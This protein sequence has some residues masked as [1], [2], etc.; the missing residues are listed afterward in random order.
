MHEWSQ[1]TS[2]DAIV[3]VLDN[4]PHVGGGWGILEIT[5]R[6]GDL[7]SAVD[8]RTT[9]SQFTMEFFLHSCLPEE[10]QIETPCKS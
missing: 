5:S 9:P 4:K 7:R 2:A 10:N 8:A 6:R 1:R 3:K